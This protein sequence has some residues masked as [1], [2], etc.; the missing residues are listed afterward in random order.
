[1]WCRRPPPD[2]ARTL[3]LGPPRSLTRMHRPPHHKRAGCS[4]RRSRRRSRRPRHHSC[5]R[6]IRSGRTPQ[7][8]RRPANLV[9]PPCRPARRPYHQRKGTPAV[10]RGCT[11]RASSLGLGCRRRS[12]PLR[13][14]PG[15][16]LRRARRT[17]SCFQE[18][19]WIP[20][21]AAAYA[22]LLQDRRLCGPGP[23]ARNARAS[24]WGHARPASP[25]AVQL[26][27]VPAAA[28]TRFMCNRGTPRRWWRPPPIPPSHHVRSERSADPDP[29]AGQQGRNPEG[30][31]PR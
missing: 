15:T 5:C 31:G 17:P 18:R 25:W 8:T 10:L 19:S 16:G 22:E 26:S 24:R 6:V 14:E 28:G 23:C 27:R 20:R 29:W 9:R 2:P 11:G 21:S 7:D 3:V 30:G 13:A 1:M 4:P 12:A